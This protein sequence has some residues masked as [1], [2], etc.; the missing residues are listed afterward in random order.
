MKHKPLSHSNTILNQFIKLIPR[1]SFDRLAKLHHAGQDFRKYNR[2]DQ[3][4]CLLSAQMTGRVSLR[5]IT[6]NFSAQKNKLYHAGAQTMTRSSL[7]RINEKQPA[8]LYQELFAVLF[9]RC[10]PVVGKHKFKFKNPLYSMDASTIELSLSV[11]PWAKFRQAKGA[12]KLHVALNHNGLIPEFID[13]TDGK[14]HEVNIGRTVNFPKDSIVVMDRGY[15]DYAWFNQLDQKKIYFVSRAKKNMKFKIIKRQKYNKGRGVTSD[16]LIELTSIKGQTYQ[17]KLRRI[18][19]KDPDTGKQYYF[20][21]NNTRLAAQ[22]I[23]DIYKDR[24]QIELFFKW[25]KQNLKIKTFIGTSENAVLTQIW[26]AMCVYLLLAYFK[27]ING[28]NQSPMTIIR[29]LHMNWFERRNLLELFS[30]P[31]PHVEN[32]S[33]NQGV[34]I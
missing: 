33:K 32:L 5:D 17:G 20:L 21:T 18:G 24:W 3:F 23:A 16:H 10:K 13:I 31:D 29:L 8:Q 11:F 19:Y 26:I 12:I 15:I 30:P 6:E 28:L 2:W 22:T 34:L 4:I 1:P 9:T 25:I 14:K 27:F 7:S